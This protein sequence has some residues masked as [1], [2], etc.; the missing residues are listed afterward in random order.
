MNAFV[1]VI[2]SGIASPS[3]ADSSSPSTSH[4][5]LLQQAIVVARSS[6]SEPSLTQTTAALPM[7]S[8]R[9]AAL[10]YARYYVASLAAIEAQ[11]CPGAVAAL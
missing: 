5:L 6:A 2:G 7:P 8:R 9:D 4:G 1:L 10:R 3:H 11:Y